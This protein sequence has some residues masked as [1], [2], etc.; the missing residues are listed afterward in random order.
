[1]DFG[2][3]E[4]TEQTVE[5]VREFVREEL[6][7]LEEELLAGGPGDLEEVLDEKRRAVESMGLW[8]PHIDEE[9]GGAG[10][11]LTEFAHVAEELGR[12]PVGH[13]VFNC[14]APDAGNMEILIDHGSERQQEEF[15][16]PLI[17]GEIRSCFSMTEKDR[18]GSNPT[19][20]ETTA[21]RDGD[22]YVI[23]GDKWFTSSADGAEF[24][25]VMAITDPEAESRY[26]RAS[27]II[28]P[29]DNPGFELVRNIPVMGHA[30]EGYFSHGEVH[31]EECRVPVENRLGSEG[32]GF[33]IA[34]NRLGPGRIHHCMRWIGICER[35]FEMMCR[36]ADQRELYPGNRLGDQ[37]MVQQ[38]IADSRAEI[39][40]A[41]LMTLRAA[42]EI[43]QSG[44]LGARTDISKIKYYVA[45]VLQEVLDRAVQV[46]GALGVTDDTPLAWWYRHE[47][48]ARIYDGPDEVHKRLVAKAELER[49]ADER[50]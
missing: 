30:G 17:D 31:Y 16:R 33:V 45:G 2:L 50:D 38:K 40:A 37:Q 25:I 18:P 32:A 19:W 24:A 10:L 9:W 35:A 11:S 3:S 14:Q 8:A 41:R 47:R 36:R 44:T 12:S 28:V 42:W 23:D 7:P 15:L 39:D 4:Q 6:Y 48:A 29:T 20:M 1:M 5:T 49:V 43:E 27:Q 46:H 21:E 34:Q 26:N 13:Y 22:E